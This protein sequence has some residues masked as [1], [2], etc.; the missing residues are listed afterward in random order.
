[1][2]PTT[3]FVWTTGRALS[4]VILAAGLIAVL[5]LLGQWWRGHLPWSPPDVATR[6][7]ARAW[8]PLD[9]TLLLVAILLP[10]LIDHAQSEKIVHPT[11]RHILPAFFYYSFLL[12]GVLV[13]A[14]RTRMG[15][16]GALGITRQNLGAAVRTG[17][18]LG[19]ATLPIVLLIAGVVSGLL[20][21]FKVPFSQQ[22]FLTVL[23]DPQLDAA[24][25]MLLIG[26]AVVLGPL[27]EEAIFRGVFLSLALH[28]RSTVGALLLVNVLFALMH[29]HLPSFLPL[30]VAGLC[31]SLG[32]LTSGSI[33]TSV[34]MH[35]IFNGEMLLLFYA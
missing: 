32:M 7:Q 30:L 21:Y 19:L 16:G 24:T 34:I 33:L 27:L 31:F 20:H 5:R 11:L 1:M 12:A 28:N 14:Q 18:E 15:I 26:L 10:A 6:L 17:V 35:A 3:P 4:L 22:E 13:A 23:E 29:L 25:Q 8:R 2:P 9:A